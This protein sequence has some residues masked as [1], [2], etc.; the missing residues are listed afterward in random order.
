M[1]VA[2]FIDNSNTFKNIK[3]IR[4]ADPGWVCFYDPLKLA[5]KLAGNRKLAYAAFYCVQ[6]PAY[7]LAEDEEHIRKYKVTTKYYVAY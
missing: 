7:L 5:K 3:R 4:E 6:P 1:K 2:V